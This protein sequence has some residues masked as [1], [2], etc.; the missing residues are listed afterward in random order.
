MT[1]D[2]DLAVAGRMGRPIVRAAGHRGATTAGESRCSAAIVS[3]TKQ[4][5]ARTIAQSVCSRRCA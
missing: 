2:Q 4:P 5:A 1:R 3:A